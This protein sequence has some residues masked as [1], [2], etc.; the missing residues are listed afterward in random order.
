LC[1]FLIKR[2]TDSIFRETFQAGQL[3][4]FAFMRDKRC[5]RVASVGGE[6]WPMSALMAADTHNHIWQANVAI[7]DHLLIRANDR[8]SPPFRQAHHG[9]RLRGPGLWRAWISVNDFGPAR[10]PSSLKLG[11][12]LCK[13]LLPTFADRGP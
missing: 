6:G 11:E 4:L 13:A 1:N 9:L 5:H 12:H 7:A 10:N 3:T 8:A 2:P